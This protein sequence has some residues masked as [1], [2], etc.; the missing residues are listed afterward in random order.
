MPPDVC[1]RD[2]LEKVLN[3]L[4]AE[5]KSQEQLTQKER[6]HLEV[7]EFIEKKEQSTK[8]YQDQDG[9]V[10]SGPLVYVENGAFELVWSRIAFFGVLQILHLYAIYYTLFHGNMTNLKTFFFSKSKGTKHQM[11]FKYD[12]IMLH[13]LYSYGIVLLECPWCYCRC[14]SSLVAQVLP[15][16]LASSCISDDRTLYRWPGMFAVLF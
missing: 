4:D 3:Q 8:Q 14:P 11:S 16:S 15:S 2:R 7:N 12:C 13:L 1:K 5:A 10:R 9:V 6:T